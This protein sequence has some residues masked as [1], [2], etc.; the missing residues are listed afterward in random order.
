MRPAIGPSC[1][2]FVYPECWHFEK[3]EIDNVFADHS[4]FSFSP[5]PLGPLN[6]IVPNRYPP[7][8]APYLTSYREWF[9]LTDNFFKNI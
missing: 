3:G 5:R 9:R 2:E 7:K 4:D 6:S 1:T 8:K